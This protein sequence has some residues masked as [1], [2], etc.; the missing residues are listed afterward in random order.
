[1]ALVGFLPEL[2]IRDESRPPDST[3]VSQALINERLQFSLYLSN[4]INDIKI[5]IIEF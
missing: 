2:F 3:D 1:V 4:D 5:S